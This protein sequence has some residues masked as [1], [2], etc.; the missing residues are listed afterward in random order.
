[1]GCVQHTTFALSLKELSVDFTVGEFKGQAYET[2]F[3]HY[4]ITGVSQID[5]VHHLATPLGNFAAIDK[6]LTSAVFNKI[7]NF[8]SVICEANQ[9]LVIPQIIDVNNC[10]NGKIIKK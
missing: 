2:H 7:S 10:Q 3:Y 4:E 1:M 5:E 8:E 9:L 6:F